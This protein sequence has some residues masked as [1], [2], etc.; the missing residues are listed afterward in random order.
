MTSNPANPLIPELLRAQQLAALQVQMHRNHRLQ[1]QE[2]ARHVA[3]RLVAV[4]AELAAVIALY[5]RVLLLQA[6][7]S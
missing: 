6:G 1:A 2:Q 4:L 5:D 3:N 7:P